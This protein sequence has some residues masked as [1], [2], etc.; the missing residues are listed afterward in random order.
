MF[1]IMRRKIRLLPLSSG[2][3][4]GERWDREWKG[5]GGGLL[6]SSGEIGAVT[7]KGVFFMESTLLGR[8]MAN[9]GKERKEGSYSLLRLLCPCRRP[10]THTHTHV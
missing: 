7:R 8:F 3:R 10:Y 6:S 9:G 5:D 4:E 1:R 2:E